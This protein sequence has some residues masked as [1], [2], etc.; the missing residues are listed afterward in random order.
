MIGD[1][2]GIHLPLLC[3]EA[4]A[5]LSMLYNFKFAL[6]LLALDVSRLIGDWRLVDPHVVQHLCKQHHCSGPEVLFSTQMN[7]SLQIISSIE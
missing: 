4:F 7:V 5:R 6:V 1:E 2:N 3:I